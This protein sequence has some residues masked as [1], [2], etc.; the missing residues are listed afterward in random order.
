[1]TPTQKKRMDIESKAGE[2]GFMKDRWGHWKKEI[3]GCQH[4]LKFQKTSL[5]FERKTDYDW[6]SIASDYF[7][8]IQVIPEGISIKR[9][10][11]K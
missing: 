4:R 7:K 8:N 1:M 10:L 3:D 2:L 11:V 5:R 6:F 9:R